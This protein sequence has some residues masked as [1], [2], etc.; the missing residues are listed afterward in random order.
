VSNL[1]KWGR[2]PPQFW[3]ERGIRPAQGSIR[4][5]VSLGRV[6][7]GINHRNPCW[8][9]GEYFVYWLPRESDPTW[10]S[11]R[12]LRTDLGGV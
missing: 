2:R 4:R 6:S 3:H 10:G 12:A 1:T 8:R 9:C 7:F 11:R 5:T